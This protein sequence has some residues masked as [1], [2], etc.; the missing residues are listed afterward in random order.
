MPS[1]TTPPPSDRTLA[2]GLSV[3]VGTVCGLVV[4]AEGSASAALPALLIYA[5][6]LAIGL[7]CGALV[8]RTPW[9]SLGTALQAVLLASLAEAACFREGLVCLIVVVPLYLLIALPCS[10]LMAWAVRRFGPPSGWLLLLLPVALAWGLTHRPSPSWEW[11]EDAIELPAPPEVVFQ[12]ISRLDLPIDTAPLWMEAIGL[13][14]ALAIEGNGASPGS[15]RRI[16]FANGT[17]LAVVTE[18]DAGRRFRLA[19]SVE[20]SGH[21]FIDH[22]VTLGES[23]FEFVPL[24]SGGTRVVHRTAYLP[25]AHPRAWFLP[26]EQRLGH[27]LQSHLLESW[28]ARAPVAPLLAQ[29]P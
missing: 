17:L 21:E 16:R 25:R 18:A 14:R 20:E 24:A 27:A 2:L 3:V 29:A 10:A 9:R 6:P 1:P 19:L 22:W 28:A 11:I 7:I 23:T 8:P 12:D 15:E 4:V 5:A 26:I 13:P